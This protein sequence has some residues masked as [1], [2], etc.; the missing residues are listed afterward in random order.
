MESVC[1]K[2]FHAAVCDEYNADKKFADNKKCMYAI[3]YFVDVNSRQELEE[4]HSAGRCVVFPCKIGDICY[5]IDP[6]HP[7]AIKHTVVG[8]TA[9]NRKAD[10]NHYMQ[11]FTNI[12]VIDTWAV[13]EDGCEWG[14]HYTVAEWV[15][16]PKTREA[17]DKKLKIIE[18]HKN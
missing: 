4:A 14:D 10:G 9:Y 17:V 18:S 13:A 15:D 2:C 11:D 6:G 7:G 1:K 8:T 3:D 5:E 12:I 16:A